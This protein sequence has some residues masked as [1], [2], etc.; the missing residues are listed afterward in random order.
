MAVLCHSEDFSIL[1]NLVAATRLRGGINVQP[2][3]I[4]G[5]RGNVD[6]LSLPIL[7]GEVPDGPARRLLA[8]MAVSLVAALRISLH[9]RVLEEARLLQ[10]AETRKV[11]L[12]NL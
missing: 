11:L 2:R 6:L 12:I 7:A 1:E 8:E 5:P 10:V 4:L 3:L 9:G